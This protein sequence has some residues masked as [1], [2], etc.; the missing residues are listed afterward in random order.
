V[1]M[2]HLTPVFLGQ[3]LK[4]SG[5][6]MGVIPRMDGRIEPL[7]AVYPKPAWNL[8]F[9]LLE[10]GSFA[11]KTFAGRC[12]QAGVADFY[13]FDARAAHYF[14]SCNLPTEVMLGVV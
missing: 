14:A 5:G 6:K 9:S 1:D 12:V 3:L 8:A 7:A 11:A 13:D 4:R 2:P 10:N